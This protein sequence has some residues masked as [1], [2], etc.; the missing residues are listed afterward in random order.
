MSVHVVRA[1]VQ[2]RSML[3]QHK[4]LADKL[5]ALERRV[6]HH[7]NAL[8]EVI[9]AVRALRAQPKPVTRPI[10]LTADL[11]EKPA[12]RTEHNRSLSARDQ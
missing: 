2:L 5:A 10:G 4:A 3:L 8:T 6:S 1:L 9:D 7:D 12:K 11:A